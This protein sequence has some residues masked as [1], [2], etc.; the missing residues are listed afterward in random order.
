MNRLSSKLVELKNTNQKALV[1]YLVAGDPDLDTTLE[2]MHLFVKSGVD[3]IE[4]GVPFTDPIAEGPTIQRAHD[5]ALKNDTSLKMILD[6]VKK[7]RTVDKETPIV[8][9]GYLNT[10]IS[11]IDMVKSAD[12]NSV[13]SILVVD[14]PG[15]LNLETYGISNPNINTI[16]LISPTTKEE[17]VESIAKNSTGF[18]YY[19]NLRGVTGSSNL[20]ID[21]I[22]KNIARIQQYTDLPTMAGFGIK[23]IED[24]KT[25]AAYSDGIVI[26]SSIVE[27]IDEESL[28]KEFGRIGKYL[29]EMKTAIS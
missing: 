6:T 12:S 4:I 9:M 1:A 5:R 25:L 2:L 24:A 21:E 29:R 28:T 3:V 23:S 10:F 27:M 14:V 20:N 15:E 7:F 18:I 13:D 19:V 22:Q 26:G 8:L 17:R 11:H 16:S